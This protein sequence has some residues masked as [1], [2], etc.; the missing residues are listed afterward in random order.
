MNGR[1]R[2]SPGLPPLFIETQIPVKQ[3]VLYESILNPEGAQY[4]VIE[5]FDLMTAE[6]LQSS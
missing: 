2:N 5:S 4:H 6:T 1:R 3:V